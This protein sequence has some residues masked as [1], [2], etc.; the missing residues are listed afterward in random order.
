MDLLNHLQSLNPAEFD[1]YTPPRGV[2]LS[3]AQVQTLRHFVRQLPQDRK[4]LLYLWR[5]LFDMD[6][7][8]IRRYA[9]IEHANGVI[10]AFR[11]ACKRCLEMDRHI[12]NLGLRPVF[13]ALIL[14][15]EIL[16]VSDKKGICWY[17]NYWFDAD[18][19]HSAVS[20]FEEREDHKKRG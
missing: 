13:E 18:I 12:S 15:Y 4:M 5:F 3:P 20:E 9:G 19:A 17:R 10:E 8:T 2:Q 6:I 16:F 1:K 11:F 14:E 7:K